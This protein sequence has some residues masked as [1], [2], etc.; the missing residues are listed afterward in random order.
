MQVKK[1][2]LE[3]MLKEYRWKSWSHNVCHLRDL[4]L[5][6]L[7]TDE[8]LYGRGVRGALCSQQVQAGLLDLCSIMLLTLQAK[9]KK[10][11]EAR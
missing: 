10:D 9:M 8:P 6:K 3:H 5:L 7:I 2:K 4:A 11:S 1:L